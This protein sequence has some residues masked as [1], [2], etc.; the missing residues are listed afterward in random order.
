VQ[1]TDIGYSFSRWVRW[2][3]LQSSD[4]V[5]FVRF[6]LD[7]PVF[8]Q[9]SNT[10]DYLNNNTAESHQTI[11]SYRQVSEQHQQQHQHPFIGPLSGTTW[12]SRYQKGKTNLDLLEQETVSGSGISWAICK[13]AP[14][15]QP[16]MMISGFVDKDVMFSHNVRNSDIGAVLVQ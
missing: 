9:Y 1:T 3:R 15:Q 6:F 8:Q 16:T 13:S 14:C 2:A 11:T 7:H 4:T 12:V 5:N 10:V